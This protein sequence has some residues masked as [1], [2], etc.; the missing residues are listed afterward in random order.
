MTRSM[1]CGAAGDAV[2]GKDRASGTGT[3]SALPR[4]SE[5]GSDHLTGR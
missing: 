3:G 4:A 1:A 5:A 2:P